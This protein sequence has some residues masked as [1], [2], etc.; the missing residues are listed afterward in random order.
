MEEFNKNVFINCP[1]DPSYRPLLMAL[2][3]AVIYLGYKPRLSFERSDSAESRIDKIV[4]LISESKFGIHDLSRMVSES[5][6]EHMRMNMP[7]ELG[8]DYGCKRL[9]GGA[10][11]QKQ[12]LVLDK[13]R[14]RFHR[15]LS[16]LSGS[17]IKNHD[18]DAFKLIKVIRE[19]FVSTDRLRNIPSHKKIWNFFND[20]QAFLH[21]K[22][23]E[24]DGHGS[25]DE[26]QEIE[27]IDHM[28]EWVACH[29]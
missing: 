14:Y 18:N 4:G 9:K 17:D 24:T 27:V 3:F 7:F 2:V 16:D 6:N 15:S 11:A 1:F 23:V 19:W 10:W 22:L 29:T 5:E 28:I 26:V 12:L 13:E 8:I 21:D 25:V 20:F